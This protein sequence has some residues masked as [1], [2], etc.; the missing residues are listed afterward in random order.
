MRHKLLALLTVKHHFIPSISTWRYIAY[1]IYWRKKGCVVFLYFYECENDW[2]I[3]KR[4]AACAILQDAFSD[5]LEH[6]SNHHTNNI[7]SNMRCLNLAILKLKIFSLIPRRLNHLKNVRRG[8]RM[9]SLRNLNLNLAK[10]I[11][12]LN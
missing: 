10:R 5:I 6:H 2:H 11:A 4:Q 3:S 8:E 12:Q 1:V 7:E 9:V